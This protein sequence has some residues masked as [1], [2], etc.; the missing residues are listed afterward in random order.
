MRK[1]LIFALLLAV[2]APVSAL[3]RSPRT[4]KK[5]NK[6]T[7]TEQTEAAATQDSLRTVCPLSLIHI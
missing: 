5:R 4:K 7:R 3:D 6:K 2:A 1:L